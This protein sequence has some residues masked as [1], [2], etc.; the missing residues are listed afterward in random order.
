M[1]SL[2][3]PRSRTARRRSASSATRIL[4]TPTAPAAENLRPPKHWPRPSNEKWP[5]IQS[6]ASDSSSAPAASHCCSSTRRS[7][8][9][10]TRA[11]SR[12]P[13]RPTEPSPPRDGLDWICVSPKAGA[14]LK[15]RTGDE[16]KLVYPQPD[17]EPAAFEALSFRHFF[18][19]PM[20]GP[21]A[22]QHAGRAALLPRSSAVA[23]EP[24]DAQAAGHSVKAGVGNLSFISGGNSHECSRCRISRP[25]AEIPIL[26]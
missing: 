15:Q 11:V 18:L 8:T 6:G 23:P 9:L 10:C 22:S 20:D 19:Q 3:G 13:S 24:A 5:A 1:Q 12:L 26:S 4:P 25:G 14:E 17:A 7:S 16:L 2:V 21:T